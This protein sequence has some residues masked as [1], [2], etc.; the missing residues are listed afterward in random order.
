[1][2]ARKRIHFNKLMFEQLEGRL[3]LSDGYDVVTTMQ[4]ADIEHR[5]LRDLIALLLKFA[6]RDVQRDHDLHAAVLRCDADCPRDSF[7]RGE[8]G[9]RGD[10]NPHGACDELSSRWHIQP[11]ATLVRGGKI[12]KR[13]GQEPETIVRDCVG[14]S[15]FVTRP[16]C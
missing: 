1:M 12:P 13:E 5:L 10:A 8:A 15:R 16:T 2:N 6:I 9:S 4:G 14:S 3:L 11:R 7:G